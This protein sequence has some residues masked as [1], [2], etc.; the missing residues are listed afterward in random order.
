VHHYAR[1]SGK[2][3]AVQN[4]VYP[5]LARYDWP[6]NVRE[7]EN[8]VERGVALNSSGVLTPADFP[9]EI[10]ET[11]PQATQLMPTSES[12]PFKSLHEHEI[13]YVTAVLEACD[14]NVVRAA[15]ILGIDRRTVY[16]ML[17]RHG[18]KRG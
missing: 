4:S 2:T 7:L 18:V 14:Q 10:R 5:L 1:A 9:S 15:K 12:G 13:D 6:G 8:A 11:S 16:R 17:K 3:I